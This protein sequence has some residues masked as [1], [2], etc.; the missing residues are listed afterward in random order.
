MAKETI[1][2]LTILPEYL[3]KI[4]SGEK[5]EEYRSLSKHYVQLFCNRR[6]DGEFKGKY[7]VANVE[8]GLSDAEKKAVLTKKDGFIDYKNINKIK[9][10]AGYALDMPYVIVNVKSIEINKFINKT[11]KNFNAPKGSE[12]FVIYINSIDE[13]GFLDKLK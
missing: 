7:H 8:Y 10:R 12:C 5:K 13:T 2:T 4:I 1:L 9:F 11:P 6:K 3:K